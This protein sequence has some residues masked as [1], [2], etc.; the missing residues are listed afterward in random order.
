VFS[1]YFCI[2][3]YILAVPKTEILKKEKEIFDNKYNNIQEVHGYDRSKTDEYDDIRLY[4]EQ[5][6]FHSDVWGEQ[7]CR[8]GKRGIGFCP[9]YAETGS[10]QY[11]NAGKTESPE[12]VH[13][14][15]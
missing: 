10:G 4:G 1:S 13:G 3:G 7:S 15:I 8:C 11:G 14:R 6:K 5:W 12:Y 2:F 9:D